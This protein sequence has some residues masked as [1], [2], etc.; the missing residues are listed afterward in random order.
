[1]SIE[2]FDPAVENN[3]D[4]VLESIESSRPP[5]WQQSLRSPKGIDTCD[6]APL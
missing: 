3:L 4:M 1:M 6:G 2:L 5:T